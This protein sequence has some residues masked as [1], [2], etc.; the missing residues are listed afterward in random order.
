METPLPG[1]TCS[2]IADFFI[3]ENVQVI[4]STDLMLKSGHPIFFTR[5]HAIEVPI[6][7]ISQSF[8]SEKS[9]DDSGR[10][11]P[12]SL[13]RR[14]GGTGVCVRAGGDEATVHI[15]TRL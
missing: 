7:P 10:V 11:I 15:S 14:E 12:R 1:Q 3:P 8:F 2:A 5:K 13:Q 6:V 4:F 9:D